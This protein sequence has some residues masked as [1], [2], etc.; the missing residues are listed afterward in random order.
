MRWADLVRN[1][2]T[3]VLREQGGTGVM[4]FEFVELATPGGRAQVFADPEC[5]PDVGYGV[6]DELLEI[7]YMKEGFPHI[8]KDDGLNSIRMSAEDGLELRTRYFGQMVCY[9]PGGLCMFDI[10]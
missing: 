9:A 8:V 5:P 4:G 2:G 6:D 1:M 3:K 7:L 10:T